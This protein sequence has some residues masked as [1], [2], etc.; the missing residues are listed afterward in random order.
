MNLQ[1]W[2]FLLNIS[3]SQKLAIV[4]TGIAGS[5][6]IHQLQRIFPEAQIQVFEA[7]SQSGGRVK[8]FSFEG[9]EYELGGTFFIEQNHNLVHLIKELGLTYKQSHMS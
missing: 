5:S 6:L 9:K 1:F 3:L 7:N 8:H 4:G 2:I